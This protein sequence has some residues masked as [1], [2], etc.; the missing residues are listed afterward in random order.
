MV[1]ADRIVGCNDDINLR[2]TQRVKPLLKRVLNRG[3]M[4]HGVVTVLQVQLVHDMLIFVYLST[5]RGDN[6]NIFNLSNSI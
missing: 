6:R 3:V 4:S 5:H 1:L 2:T